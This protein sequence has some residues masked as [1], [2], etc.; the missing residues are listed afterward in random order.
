[1][2]VR[3]D[4]LISHQFDLDLYNSSGQLVL[5]LDKIANN[6]KIDI[7]NKKFKDQNVKIDDILKEKDN[8]NIN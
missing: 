7:S 6:T 3:I 1:M 5:D 8:I 2:T 4:N